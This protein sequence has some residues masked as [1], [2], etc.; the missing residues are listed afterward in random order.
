M[1]LIFWFSGQ[2]A[3]ESSASSGSITELIVFI[4]TRLFKNVSFINNEAFIENAEFFV[5]K[6]AHMTLYCVLFLLVLLSVSAFAE[7]RASLKRLMAI[8]AAITVAYA[9]S[10]EIHQLFV[11]GRSSE[12]RDV[13][14][15][16]AGAAVGVLV[17]SLVAVIRKR[18]A[19]QRQ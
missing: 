2:T 3:D 12:V 11:P 19:L 9:A 14:I 4:V 6:A 17:V 5:R 1:S 16:A 18:R 7:G 13:I 10:D 8:S 15:D